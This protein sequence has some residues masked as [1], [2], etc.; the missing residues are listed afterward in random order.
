MPNPQEVLTEYR[1]K[2]TEI[3][4]EINELRNNRDYSDEYKDEQ[5]SEMIDEA[6]EIQQRYRERYEEALESQIEDVKSTVAESELPDQVAELDQL[7]QV[8][9][10]EIEVLANKYENNY[11]AQKRLAEIARNH[12]LMA[13]THEVDA[14]EEIKEIKQKLSHAGDMF[15]KEPIKD[16]EDAR[17]REAMGLDV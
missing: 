17:L 7:D 6:K 16:Y 4:D 3:K 15:N 10:T 5:K 1:E 2:M 12:D 13:E 14:E 8:S 11:I 9:K